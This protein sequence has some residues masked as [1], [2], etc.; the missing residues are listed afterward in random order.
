[1]SER[2]ERLVGASEAAPGSRK[3]PELSRLK[4]GG[5][6]SPNE[7][8]WLLK[9]GVATCKVDFSKL[10]DR[11]FPGALLGY[12]KTMEWFARNK[13]LMSVETVHRSFLDM[14]DHSQSKRVESV[15]DVMVLSYLGAGDG[16]PRG[17]GVL[18]AFLTKWREQ[19]NPG[20]DDSAAKAV[21]KAKSGS[22]KSKEQALLT[23]CPITGP[24][25]AMERDAFHKAYNEAFAQGRL[26]EAQYIVLTL[27]RVFGARPVQLALMKLKDLE[28]VPKDG[29]WEYVLSIPS[30]KKAEKAR[31]KFKKRLLIPELGELMR[32]HGEKV[33]LRYAS[34]AVPRGEL[35]MF[36]MEKI[37]SGHRWSEGYKFHK[38][39]PGM[40]SEIRYSEEKVQCVSERTG[41][42]MHISSRR[43]R[44][45]LGTVLAEEGHPAST[46]AEALDH[47]S[48]GSVMSY[49]ALTGKLHGRLNKAMALQLAPLA[50]AFEGKLVGRGEQGAG[51]K[52]IR[53]IRV[54]GT[55]EPVGN[56]GKSS[57][58][59]YAAP[60][61]CYT[62]KNFRPFMDAP[63]EP[64][65]DYLLAERER[66]MNASGQT[67]AAVEDRTI[68]AIA[69]VVSKCDEADNGKD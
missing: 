61:A 24:F 52:T 35:P 37:P 21:V 4:D 44:Y 18:K 15:T 12:K 53:D 58:C 66:L 49:V 20:I 28:A 29:A 38:T 33:A 51:G 10:G 47:E 45:T 65:L 5:E 25:S 13:S 50:Q 16:F 63:H 26:T 3:L 56:C 34:E 19:R 17:W 31:S 36:P 46:I 23:L 57:V 2:T 55:Y 14:L 64:L 1:M 60:I 27:E 7:D 9:S 69:E 48:L 39:G 59:H 42:A 68:L 40:R 67:M 22:S 62:C 54:Q 43:F 6:F 30:A 41:E 11:L 32:S 8:V